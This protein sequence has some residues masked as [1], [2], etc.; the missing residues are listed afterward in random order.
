MIFTVGD[1][2]REV[3]NMDV[4]VVKKYE[5]SLESFYKRVAGID[6]KGSASGIYGEIVDAGEEM[7]DKMFGEGAAREM[8]RESRSVRKIMTA[9]CALNSFMNDVGGVVSEMRRIG[10]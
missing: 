2:S 4:Y 1:F 10:A 7:M 9:V 3:D 8:F 5:E 6:M